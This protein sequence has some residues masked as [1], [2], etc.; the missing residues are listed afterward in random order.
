MKDKLLWELEYDFKTEMRKRLNKVIEGCTIRELLDIGFSNNYLRHNFT[1]SLGFK[2]DDGN[3]YDS[4]YKHTDK[5]FDTK[6][7][8]DYWDNDSNG[9]TIV[10]V[11]LVNDEDI[12]NL[13]EDI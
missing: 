2:S 1:Y 9:Y 13:E 6:V 3:Y 7:K 8:F 4:E 11:K 10:Y 12:K 5:F